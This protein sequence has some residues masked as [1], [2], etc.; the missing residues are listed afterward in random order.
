MTKP[1]PKF[2][3]PSLSEFL[4]AFLNDEINRQIADY[5]E[6][7]GHDRDELSEDIER[8][9]R[10]RAAK[11]H[12][13][14]IQRHLRQVLKAFPELQNSWKPYIPDVTKWMSRKAIIRL[15]KHSRFGDVFNHLV[16]NRA[17]DEDNEYGL[18]NEQ[19]PF[20]IVKVNED[21]YEQIC[22]ELGLSK[23]SIQKYL[24]S[25]CELKIIRLLKKGGGRRKDTS[26]IY[27]IGYEHH[28]YSMKIFRPFL[29]QTMPGMKI[30]ETYKQN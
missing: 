5:C 25:F 11:E 8:A 7:E 27:A 15:T 19:W 28:Y 30:L 23:I 1:K 22:K 3:G 9:I 10:L 12:N 29:T 2:E 18:H 24:F 20:V 6:K 17:V 14:Q 16:A 4:N 26:S 21:F 13:R